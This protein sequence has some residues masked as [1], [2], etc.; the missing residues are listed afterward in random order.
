MRGRESQSL[1]QMFCIQVG[2]LI[3]LPIFIVG[4]H[5]FRE[6]GLA[7]SLWAIGG[8][9]AIVVLLALLMLWMT[10]HHPLTTMENAKR[11]FGPKAT[12]WLGLCFIIA[13]VGW[14]ALQLNVV[15]QSVL[16]AFGIEGTIV[17]ALVTLALGAAIILGSLKGMRFLSHLSGVCALALIATL[18]VSFW[19]LPTAPLPQ[20]SSLL[21]SPAAVSLV[22]G[23]V[24]VAIID[25]PSY[26]RHMRSFKE[27]VLAVICVFGIAVPLLEGIGLYFAM[28]YTAPDLLAALLQPNALVWKA[29]VILFVAIAG[30]STNHCNLY[31]AHMGTVAL[32]PRLKDSHVILGLG[33]IGTLLACFPL[34]AHIGTLLDVMTMGVSSMGGIILARF[35]LGKEVLAQERIV[36]VGAWIVGMIAGILSLGHIAALTGVVPLDVFLS[37]AAGAACGYVGT[38]FIRRKAYENR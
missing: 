33:G 31:S 11:Y 2:G 24:L 21:F 36:H 22:F 20:F 30:W 32:F 29:W 7:A 14:F 8:G 38:K 6:F 17:S 1:V 9:N 13:L 5:L 26:F 23:S 12:K 3:C 37:G 18:G 16:Y 27:G 19:L 10:K 25:M 35:L 15:A 28:H 34:L 4:Y